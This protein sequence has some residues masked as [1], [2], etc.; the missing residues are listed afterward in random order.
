MREVRLS[1]QAGLKMALQ[2]LPSSPFKYT[3][4]RIIGEAVQMLD[5][6]EL[7]ISQLNGEIEDM[8][9]LEHWNGL[10]EEGK[11]EAIK[12]AI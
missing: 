9:R 11:N 6:Q 1:T 10:S 4:T 3:A 5:D 12:K 8:Q 2:C 7:M